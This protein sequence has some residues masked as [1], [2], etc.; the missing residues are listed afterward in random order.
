MVIS[1]PDSRTKNG[2][3]D[4][5]HLQSSGDGE[6]TFVFEERE[7]EKRGH[8]GDDGLKKKKKKSGFYATQEHTGDCP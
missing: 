8:G 5:I 6:K 3:K 4:S 7:R 2:R 1:Q